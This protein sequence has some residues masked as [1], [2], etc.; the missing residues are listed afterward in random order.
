[1]E[2]VSRCARRWDGAHRESAKRAAKSAACGRPR[3]VPKLDRAAGNSSRRARPG[4]PHT[5]AHWRYGPGPC[6]RK[7]FPARVKGGAP[8]TRRPDERRT[9]RAEFSAPSSSSRPSGAGAPVRAGRAHAVPPPKARAKSR[10]GA[11]PPVGRIQSPSGSPLH[12]TRIAPRRAQTGNPA[13]PEQ[14]RNPRWKSPR[15]RSSCGLHA[16]AASPPPREPFR[17]R[18][19]QSRPRT[20]TRTTR[21][22]SQSPLRDAPSQSQKWSPE[23]APAQLHPKHRTTPQTGY[24]HCAGRLF[25]KASTRTER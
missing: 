7:P 13:W 19:P 11:R 10:K 18:Q 6:H 4:I 20:D 1:M 23:K 14:S 9:A 3:P 17:P 5:P 2:P 25:V 12:P 22:A 16:D 24:L 8:P 21:A 15:A